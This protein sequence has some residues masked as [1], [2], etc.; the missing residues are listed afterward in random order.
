LALVY[1]P[2]RAVLNDAALLIADDMA[3]NFQS[4]SRVRV[5]QLP[6]HDGRSSAISMPNLNGFEAAE[7][8]KKYLPSA[9]I[10]FVTVISFSPWLWCPSRIMPQ[11]PSEGKGL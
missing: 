11:L 1:E 8:I 5:S 3:I 7:T 2:C 4:D 9:T 6:L 10:Y